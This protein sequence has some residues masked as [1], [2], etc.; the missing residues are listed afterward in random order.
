MEALLLMLV[1]IG[2]MAAAAFAGIAVRRL[3]PEHHT[4]DS[5]RDA[6]LR[7]VGLVV[8]LSAVVLGF[9]VSSAKSYFSAVEGQL[10]E[11]A[12]DVAMLDRLL[13]R[14]GTEAGPARQLLRQSV[15]LAV[16]V[17]WPGHQSSLPQS[18]GDSGL[19]ASERLSDAVEGLPEADPHLARLREQALGQLA[20]VQ[21][22][23]F[24][25]SRI[26][27][28]RPQVPMLAVVVSW[29]VIIFFGFGVV[30]PPTGTARAS[31][32]LAAV[33][34]AGA[35]FLIIELYS[36]VSGLLQIPASTLEDALPA[37]G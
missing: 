12:A 29:L 2:V 14:Y 24:M 17:V 11:I 7:S 8:T 10:T 16:S 25:L 20:D 4:A 5:S 1:F 23:G 30:S 18:G 3:L 15:G 34:A 36:P 21:H 37:L 27:H 28:S 26:A 9:L 31:M 32:I 33:A 35:L 13:M 6:V 22:A 19:Q